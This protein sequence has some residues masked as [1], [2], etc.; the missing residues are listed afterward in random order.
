MLGLCLGYLKVMHPVKPSQHEEATRTSAHIINLFLNDPL[1]KAVI[2]NSSPLNATP[3]KE[4]NALQIRLISLENTLTNLAKATTE[5]RKEIKQ[6][7]TTTSQPT[8]AP[9]T[10]SKP[11]TTPPTYAAKAATPHRPSAVVGTAAYTWPD[12]HRPSPADICATI[13]AALSHT[14]STQVRISAV[15]WTAKGNLVFWGGAN[16]MATQL[17]T[18]LPHISEALHPSLSALSQS[19]PQTPPALRPNV[20]WSKLRLNA[21]PTGVTSN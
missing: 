19:A 2:P 10:T 7:P 6:Q 16:T 3:T 4:L 15:R 21:I 9:T 18:A 14:N 17:T 12:N 11:V 20:K 13:N 1:V 8:K 5:V